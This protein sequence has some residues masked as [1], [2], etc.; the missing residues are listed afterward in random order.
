MSITENLKIIQEKVFNAE[1]LAGRKP[2]S[3]RLMAVSKF[4]P[5]EAVREVINAGLTLFGE[6]RVQE[7]FDK[8][9]AI[10]Q[11]TSEVELHLIGNLQ[12]NKVKHIIQLASCIQS[13]DRSG[14]LEEIEKQAKS[15]GRPVDILFEYLT[16]ED[17]KSGYTDFDTL[18]RSVDLLSHMTNVRCRGLMT[19]A[20]F[21]SDKSA[22]RKSFRTLVSLQKECAARYPSL[23][24]SVLS[25]GMSA[26]FETAI[27][28]GSTLIRVGRAIFG[29]RS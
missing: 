13:V 22:I 7:A 18:F 15:A 21:T 16:A 25:M 3:V 29:E 8:F 17:S 9:P 4:H 23:D 20:P 28:E 1:K 11:E 14:L 5:A 24:F 10:L 12:R 2:S 27:E 6:N 26:D 19:L